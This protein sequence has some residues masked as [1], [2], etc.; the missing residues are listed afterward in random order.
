ML[1]TCLLVTLNLLSY[2]SNATDLFDRDIAR[3]SVDANGVG[4]DNND[5]NI[6]FCDEADGDL[7]DD[8][9]DDGIDD[10]EY[11]DDDGGDDDDDNDRENDGS[12]YLDGFCGYEL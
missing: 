12:D 1:T 5:N 10:E 9:G 7:E 3:R 6:D 8:G 11:D 2:V 4:T